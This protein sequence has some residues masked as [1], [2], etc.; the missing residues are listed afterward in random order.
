MSTTVFSTDVDP[1]TLQAANQVLATH[2]VTL[3]EAFHKLMTY[4]VLEGRMPYFECFEPNEKT[5]TA[6]AEAA[7]GDL[8]TVGSVADLMAELNED[9]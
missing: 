5:L 3:T 6:M 9:D 8:V 2:G 1:D 7:R 4:I